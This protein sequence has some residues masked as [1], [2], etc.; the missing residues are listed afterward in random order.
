LEGAMQIR[1]TALAVVC[2]GFPDRDLEYTI[3]AE[4][5]DEASGLIAEYLRIEGLVCGAVMAI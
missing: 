3:E 4:S 2:E 1:V 5:K